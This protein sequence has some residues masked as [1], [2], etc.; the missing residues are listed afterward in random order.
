MYE[1]LLIVGLVIAVGLNLYSLRAICLAF[2]TVW[3]LLIIPSA[4]PDPDVLGFYE[5]PVLIICELLFA[6]IALLIN[7]EA[8][9]YVSLCCLFN[10]VAHFIGMI[11][12]A[13]ND[14]VYSFYKPLICAT[15]ASQ[16]V[17]LILASRPTTSMVLHVLLTRQGFPYGRLGKY[18]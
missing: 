6:Y 18:L 16:V 12:Y 15:E 17:A 14:A 8:S 3:F 11:G 1:G 5:F 4:L 13:Y 10:I 2:A 9:N 7:A